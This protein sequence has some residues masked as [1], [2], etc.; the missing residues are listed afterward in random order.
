MTT[1]KEKQVARLELSQKL[2]ELGYPQESLFYWYKS[3]EED[4]WKITDNE[5]MKDERWS[6]CSAPTVAELG[7]FLKRYYP[8]VIEGQTIVGGRWAIDSFREKTEADV[9]A[10]A[11]VYILEN[12]LIEL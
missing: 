1:P 6:W 10:T 3:V 7:E 5:L 11:I 9:R 4:T 2:K 8:Q 12:K